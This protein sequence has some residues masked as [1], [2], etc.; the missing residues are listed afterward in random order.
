MAEHERLHR[1]GPGGGHAGGDGR[2]VL[3][4]D[5]HTAVPAAAVELDEAPPSAGVEQVPFLGRLVPDAGGVETGHL[6]PLFDQRPD[7]PLELGQ[8]RDEEDL[9]LSRSF[10]GRPSQ[11]LRNAPANS[12]LTFGP[13]GTRR[14]LAS[15]NAATASS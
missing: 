8:R 12:G 1:L 11:N 3:V 2:A 4:A 10:A 7:R 15:G 5:D 6:R 13:V 9:H 14:V